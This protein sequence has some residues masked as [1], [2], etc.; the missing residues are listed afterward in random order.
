MPPD[1]SSS[2][3]A[4]EIDHVSYTYPATGLDARQR[5][6]LSDVDFTVAPGTRLGILGPNGGGKSTLIKLM[7]GLIRPSSG[8]V[9]VFGHSPARARKQGLI[10][11]LPQRIEA[12]RAWP[13]SVEQ[14]VAMP[15][16]A[17]LRPWAR[18]GDEDR[19][20]VDNAL[21][22][23]E[24][25]DLRYRPIGALSGGQLQRVMIARAIAPRPRLLVLDEPMVGVDIA[26]QQRFAALI[27]TLHTELNLTTVVVT[28]DLRAIAAISDQIA[29]L[30]RTLHFHAS[31]EGLTPAVLAQVFAHDI[32][33]AL[34]EIHVD[35]H[36]A[37]D[38]DDPSHTHRSTCGC[39][40]P[41]EHPTPGQQGGES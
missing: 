17:K 10:G 16:A 35:A 32:L 23:L 19:A 5:E 25:T 30:A 8:A 15:L 12:E 21:R 29:C 36:A 2:S 13:L 34:G 27:D 4:V 33:G 14:V 1:A 31:P 18:L 26:V 3:P 7:L 38:C 6:A 41:H 24:V 20:A 28:H 9:R 40:H 37:H 11:Y 22:L 39:D